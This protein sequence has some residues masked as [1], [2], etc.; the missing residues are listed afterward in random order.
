MP[1][2]T[3]NFPLFTADTRVCE[4]T[5]PSLWPRKHGVLDDQRLFR[6]HH[7]ATGAFGGST[8]STNPR[9][10]FSPVIIA[11]RTF[12][13]GSDTHCRQAFESVAS[14]ANHRH[15][16]RMTRLPPK[17]TI[18]FRI[19]RMDMHFFSFRWGFPSRYRTREASPRVSKEGR[20][21]HFRIGF[22]ALRQPV[23]RDGISRSGVGVVLFSFSSSH[24]TT[25]TDTRARWAG[26]H[27]V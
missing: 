18:A 16:A 14:P 7:A 17:S 23:K 21:T 12:R 15:M 13:L 24:S 22:H 25:M 2:C 3:S 10:R 26:A 1:F 5:Q 19:A 8:I 4:T 20:I 27:K 11:H 6:L 9:G